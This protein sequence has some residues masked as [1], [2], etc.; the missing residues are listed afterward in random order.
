MDHATGSRTARLGHVALGLGA[1]V[2]CT[3]SASSALLLL[4]PWAGI[5][6]Q[7][8]GNHPAVTGKDVKNSG[9]HPCGVTKGI[10]EE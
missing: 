3:R 8:T 6:S 1:E 4:L 5:Q 2:G 7:G 10:L 9:P